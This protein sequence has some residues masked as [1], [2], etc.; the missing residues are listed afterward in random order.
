MKLIKF[1][2]FKNHD[3]FITSISRFNRNFY[4]R[5]PTTLNGQ[6]PKRSFEMFNLIIAQIQLIYERNSMLFI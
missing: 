4:M 6:L 1:Q 2:I 3:Y 5:S